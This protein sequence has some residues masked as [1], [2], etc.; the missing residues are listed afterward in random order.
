M[1][2]KQ[3][4][5]SWRIF[6]QHQK[7]SRQVRQQHSGIKVILGAANTHSTGWI[8]T[9][10][11][12]V[13]ITSR[14][15]MSRHFKAGVVSAF[16]AEHV[17][18]HL[19][20]VQAE[21]A[22]RNCYEALAPGGYLRVAVPDGLHSDPAYIDRVKPG[23]SGPGADDHKILYNYQTLS[24]LLEKVGYKVRLL[25]WFDEQSKFHHENW[26]VEDGLIR[27]STRFDPRNQSNPT[28]YTS[29][30]IDASKP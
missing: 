29:L 10:Y 2:I 23:G 15:S 17:W 18:E 16:L 27:R 11:P 14:D 24:A 21:A 3:L 28:A 26:D 20:A 7:I 5:A 6:L 8:S 19:T 13:D 1:C 4:R 22:C 9:D 12:I 30:I 25:E